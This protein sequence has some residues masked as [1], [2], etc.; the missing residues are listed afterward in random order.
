MKS[1]KVGWVIAVL[2]LIVCVLVVLVVVRSGEGIKETEDSTKIIGEV[3]LRGILRSPEPSYP[4]WAEK[5]GIVADVELKF[6]VLPSGEIPSIEVLESS[7]WPSLDRLASEA[8]SQWKFEPIER[9]VTQ[10]GII[11]FCFRPK[12][13][14]PCGKILEA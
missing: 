7:G 6:W 1:K 4:E 13:T 10:W 11:T 2:V 8:L 5:Q 14:L 12:K 3:A 9:N